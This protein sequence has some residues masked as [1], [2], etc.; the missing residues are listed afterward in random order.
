[1]TRFS[2][3]LG[4]ALL[5]GAAVLSA[6][7]VAP[8]SGMAQT[9]SMPDGAVDCGAVARLPGGSWAVL[10]PATIS[11]G[12]RTMALMPGQTYIPSEMVGGVEVAA[13]LDR[14]CGNP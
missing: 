6:I 4:A 3:G 5:G 2:N 13:V 9:G 14:N 8:S 1:M 10:R 11:P 12:G 7:C